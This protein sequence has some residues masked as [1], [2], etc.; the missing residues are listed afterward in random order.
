MTNLFREIHSRE[1]TARPLRVGR[2]QSGLRSYRLFEI[3]PHHALDD[4]FLGFSV[5]GRFLVSYKYDSKQFFLRFWLFPPSQPDVDGHS[6]LKLFAETSLCRVMYATRIHDIPSVRFVQS[7]L[8]P[9]T[10]IIVSSDFYGGGVISAFGFMPDVECTNCIAAS[11]AVCHGLQCPFH[12]RL[13]PIFLDLPNPLS[14][15]PASYDRA[16]KRRRRS[17]LPSDLLPPCFMGQTSRVSRRRCSCFSQAKTPISFIQFSVC[18]TTGSIRIAWPSPDAQ[19]KVLTCSF[20]S[21]NHRGVRPHQLY[22]LPEASSLNP[23]HA[24]LTYIPPLL[25]HNYCSKC[26]SW[27]PSRH[28]PCDEPSHDT[29]CHATCS[30][31][32]CVFA[33]PLPILS[34]V[35]ELEANSDFS[36]EFAEI[37]T[38][39]TRHN[40]LALGA[41]PSLPMGL[42]QSTGGLSL[43]YPTLLSGRRKLLCCVHV[44]YLAMFQDVRASY[45]LWTLISRSVP[46]WNRESSA[47]IDLEYD[48]LVN[49]PS[50]LSESTSDHD[51]VALSTEPTSIYNQLS[52]EDLLAHRLSGQTHTSFDLSDWEEVKPSNPAPSSTPHTQHDYSGRTIAYLEEVVFDLPADCVDDEQYSSFE[53]NQL[54]IFVPPEEQNLLL[55]YRRLDDDTSENIYELI[56]EINL[57]TGERCLFTHR[58]PCNGNLSRL[59]DL[60]STCPSRLSHTDR[61]GGL[62]H[63]LNNIQMAIHS[64]S[65]KLITDPQ[66]GYTVYL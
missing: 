8:N 13:L 24:Q 21:Q 26:Y 37:Q 19:V 56:D 23:G 33:R 30:R 59:R 40:C 14:P 39:A 1:L 15:K 20:E 28:H 50:S 55:V 10:F 66:G 65:L 54:A 6:C 11:A 5:C 52:P 47:P 16:R 51:P 63:E 58:K 61:Y 44:N 17:A 49:S 38:P 22:L 42:C 43:R 41:I 53:S 45:V 48:T 29:P 34:S 36:R 32:Q 27:P 35:Q 62:I 9:T 31:P 60:V 12:T 18:S 64:K 46:P 4:V 2:Y 57:S 7:Y 3:L 25:L